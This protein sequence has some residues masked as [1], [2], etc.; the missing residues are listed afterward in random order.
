LKPNRSAVER[1][2]FV[3]AD[4]ARF[5][6]RS[7]AAWGTRKN[8]MSD[9]SALERRKYSA[10]ADKFA[11]QFQEAADRQE[12]TLEFRA[13]LALSLE[14]EHGLKQSTL[15]KFI[16]HESKA[17][18][19]LQHAPPL[20]DRQAKLRKIDAPPIEPAIIPDVSAAVRIPLDAADKQL[21][22]S[23]AALEKESA[24]RAEELLEAAKEA[25]KRFKSLDA[26]E[27][28]SLFTVCAAIHNERL[29]IFDK[30]TIHKAAEKLM[31]NPEQE[32]SFRGIQGGRKT[33]ING[34]QGDAFI[35][36]VKLE[37]A[38]RDQVGQ[39]SL[40]GDKFNGWIEKRRQRFFYP[41]S[42]VPVPAEP[43]SNHVISQIKAELKAVRQKTKY[44][45][46]RRLEAFGD[47]RN[48]VSWMIA[49]TLGMKDVPLELRFN[50]DDS[51]LMFGDHNEVAG[52]AY[53]SESVMKLLKTIHRSMGAQR[54]AL[55]GDQIAACLV[56]LGFLASALGL[57]HISI[58]KIYDR[59]ISKKH[60][61]RLEYVNT[62]DA[63]DIYC[64]YIR[65]K[66]KGAGALEDAEETESELGDIA[67]GGVPGLGD[68]ATE[69]QVAELVF[70]NVLGPKIADLKAEYFVKKRHRE[71]VGFTKK[72][73]GVALETGKAAYLEQ[74]KEEYVLH[75]SQLADQLEMA[76]PAR[77]CD[78]DAAS[79]Q[80]NDD[81]SSDSNESDADSIC[82]SDDDT[83]K[84][85]L[86]DLI[87]FRGH[88][89]KL[90]L[91]Y[92]LQQTNLYT[93]AVC[94]GMGTG[95]AYVCNACNWIAHPSCVLPDDEE[96][97]DYLLPRYEMSITAHL[98]QQY[99]ERAVLVVDGCIGQIRALVG[100]DDNLGSIVSILRPLGIDIL[101]GPAQLSPCSNALD[102]TRCFS[103]LKGQKPKW[104]MRSS[105]ATPTMGE[106]IRN[107]FYAVLK[108][109]SK[110]RRNAFELTLRNIESAISEVFTVR[111]IRR[112]WE[113]S[114]LLDLNYHQIMSHWLPWNQQA[115]WQ[116]AGIEALF[117]A[118][119][120]EMATRGTLSDATMQAMQPYFAADFKM[121]STDRSSLAVPRQRGM[122]LSI[123]IRVQEFVKRATSILVEDMQS[124]PDPFPI[125]PK[126]NSKTSKAI[127]RCKGTYEYTEEGWDEHKKTE[128]HKKCV[129]EE[130]LAV[131]VE[132]GPVFRHA[133]G[134]D[135]MQ[136]ADTVKLKE[137]CEEMQA[138][139]AFG[140]KL[141][142]RIMTDTDLVWLRMLPDRILLCDYGLQAGQA[143]IMRQ[144]CEKFIQPSTPL[145][146]QRSRSLPQ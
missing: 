73:D 9:L 132:S 117:P 37:F 50:Y 27:T 87:D 6:E 13:N 140:K 16:E 52:V 80:S 146:L 144:L 4:R 61:L 86:P 19:S 48:Y 46:G 25:V 57:L 75:E 49:A 1:P 81:L 145:T 45:S 7:L 74:K 43:L 84:C 98:D 83:Y 79:K 24:Y 59:A 126:M 14:K 89:H 93:C 116:I 62:I 108:D 101:K 17:P 53:T 137:I 133:S 88:P 136:R 138:N 8:S 69:C 112:G 123:W 34:D 96:D 72:M 2:N 56:V 143:H 92:D 36:F 40:K 141:I 78:S 94:S 38:K 11:A 63:C 23:A 42:L 70:N 91:E 18:S 105:C 102:C 67:H 65:G 135:Y 51:S 129:E 139:Q 82:S 120:F 104:S 35:E 95:I 97:V 20:A 122:Y 71:T 68:H 21:L 113:K 131:T 30:R 130:Q 85:N 124:A 3:R 22:Q 127:C 100:K 66:Q 134:M 55:S 107:S 111:R 103:T 28:K 128:K 118:F 29:Y 32:L 26:T 44:V 12:L 54:D 119:F 5:R 31:Q 15:L 58:V 47:P 64:L 106:Y 41:E 77:E 114:G 125:N 99:D 60:N 90:L 121:F 115:P 76:D 33:A 110:G 39:D 142:S 109:V 10:V